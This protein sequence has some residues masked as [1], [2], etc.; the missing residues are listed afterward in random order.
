MIKKITNNKSKIFDRK[1]YSRLLLD[2]N[3]SQSVCIYPP[4]SKS[5]VTQAGV[6][7]KNSLKLVKEETLRGT[8]LK[9]E[10]ILIWVTLGV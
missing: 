1:I 5:E 6:A 2:I 10:P 4:M 8:G 9:G 3:S 7:R